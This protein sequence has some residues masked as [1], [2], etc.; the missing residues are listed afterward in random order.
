MLWAEK[1]RSLSAMNDLWL[2][3]SPSDMDDDETRKERAAMCRGIDMAMKIVREDRIDEKSTNSLV[4]ALR[5]WA[6]Q[7]TMP[8]RR[9][10]VLEAADRRE[11][12][13]AAHEGRHRLEVHNIGNVDIPAG[14][15]KDQFDA[16]MNNVVEAIEHT[17]RGESWPY[18]KG[19]DSE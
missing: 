18:D 19:G 3:T 2:A 1:N 7:M 5:K 13:E 14:V 10:V 6:G 9:Y 12:L 4:Q 15:T 8:G 16:V 11:A 17:D